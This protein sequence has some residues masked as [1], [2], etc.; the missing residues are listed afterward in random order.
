[1]KIDKSKIEQ[2]IREKVE[3]DGLTDA[4]IAQML[5]VGTSTISH[6]RNKYNIR[7]V[8]TFKRKF[9]E[10][11]GPDAIKTFD[12]MV[13]NRVT[14]QEIANYF[15]FTRE[16]ARLV[17]NKLYQGSY[18]EHLRQRRYESPEVPALSHSESLSLYFDLSTFGPTEIAE[19]IGLLSDIYRD[20]GG[21]GLIIDDLTLFDPHPVHVPVEV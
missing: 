10:K 7:P 3:V 15:G 20:I 6:W 9:R 16:Y 8:D 5:D 18:N 14:L 13:R 1:M 4:Q 19:V 11:Y 2:F 21:D 12:M 17:Y